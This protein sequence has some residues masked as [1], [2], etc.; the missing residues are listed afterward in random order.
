[1]TG[2]RS[3]HPEVKRLLDGEVTLAD[4]A[5]GL[6]PE[7]EE[8]L[9]MLAQVD[10]RAPA[11]TPWFE[12]RV[13]AEVRRRPAPARGRWW[14]WLNESRT[15]RF[16]P[17]LALAAGLAGLVLVAVS[18]RGRAPEAP[19][20]AA[21]APTPTFVRFVLYAP[22][23]HRVTLAGSFNGWDAAA[24]PLTPAGSGL[25]T[26]TVPLKPGHHQYGFMLDGREWLPDPSA[27]AVDDGFGRRNSV[28]T[29]GSEDV[30]AS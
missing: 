10:R 6:R 11:L 3:Y 24:T 12:Q 19:A 16:R 20:V 2:T 8:A 17:R 1:M 14:A 29:V 23:A 28:L 5:P 26:V 18:L 27:P 22:Q 30:V 21:A 15:L 25:W 13:M 7:G 9:A 4:L